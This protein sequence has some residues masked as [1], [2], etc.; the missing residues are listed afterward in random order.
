MPDFPQS[1]KWTLR[2]HAIALQGDATF[3]TAADGSGIWSTTEV[4]RKTALNK[5]A[6]HWATSYSSSGGQYA[7]SYIATTLGSI[8]EHGSTSGSLNSAID[9]LSDGDAL[10]LAAGSYTIDA[11]QCQGYGSDS[12]RN[13][14][15][16][17][18]GNT[19]N[20]N[21]VVL[22]VTHSAQRGKHIFASVDTATYPAAT[23]NK[24]IAF[25][26]YK[27]LAT[28]TTSYINA[29]AVGYS[30]DPAAG[31]AV[32]CIFDFNNSNVC[33]MYDN[34]NRTTHDIEFVRCT[35]LNFNGWVAS[36]SGA[37]GQII[38]GDSMFDAAY[39]TELRATVTSS[40]TAYVSVADGSY[41][42]S[43]YSD[44]HLYIPNTAA[45]F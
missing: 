16:L 28:S 18:A 40:T 12:W 1:G 34:Y 29:I 26:R 17:I 27:R 15:I 33:W 43:T 4:A 42:T 31:R 13:K 14:N 20:A 39:S 45:V 32:N 30:S 25:V 24:Q 44:G 6:G 11:L 8:T 38:V 19:Q 37:A 5:W 23:V 41:N 10:L 35:F 7:T 3:P 21:D 36:Y 2:E 9:A 22:E